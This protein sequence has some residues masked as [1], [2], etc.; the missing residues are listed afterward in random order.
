MNFSFQVVTP[1]GVAY[2]ET[3]EKISLPTTSGEIMVYEGHAPLVSVLG[4]GEMIIT[5]EKGSEGLSMAVSGG[6]VEMR[7]TGE[8]VVL[9]DMALRAD[10]IDVEEAEKARKRAEELLKEQKDVEDIDFARIQAMI[11]REMAKIQVGNKY[12]G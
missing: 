9:T 4:S 1:S 3:I 11:D 5:K 6:V 12:R 8:L 7:H 10:D 2:A